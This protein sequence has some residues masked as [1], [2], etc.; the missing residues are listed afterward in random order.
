MD[1]TE[2]HLA[3]SGKFIVDVK[4][5]PGNKIEVYIDAPGRLAITDCVDLSR[6][7]EGS[8]DREKEDFS[9][10]VSSPGAT[11]P[12]K[13]KEQYRKYVGTSVEAKTA[14][15]ATYTGKL[16]AADDDKITIETSRRESKPVGKGKHTITENIS[17]TYQQ[18]KETKSVLP[19]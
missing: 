5:L 7:I 16:L 11:E 17:F 10:E 19:F 15:G 14:D 2:A 18:L 9:L 4:V 6:H 3:G 1:L 12:F 8:L 13:V